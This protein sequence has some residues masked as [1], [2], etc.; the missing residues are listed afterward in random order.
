MCLCDINFCMHTKIIRAGSAISLSKCMASFVMDKVKLKCRKRQNEKYMKLFWRQ[1][2][3]QTPH[4][5]ISPFL[6]KKILQYICILT[7][8]LQD[9]RSLHFHFGLVYF[10]YFCKLFLVTFCVHFFPSHCH[11][12][13]RKFFFKFATF[14]FAGKRRK[15]SQS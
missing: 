8:K 3:T 13:L 5:T 15:I 9:Q 11:S 6:F 10:G 7:G 1:R 12:V 4:A 14:F 2:T